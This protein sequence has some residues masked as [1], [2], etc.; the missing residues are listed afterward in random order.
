M[1]KKWKAAEE[2][3][4]VAQ[5]R[6]ETYKVTI[7]MQ[8]YIKVVLIWKDDATKQKISHLIREW[9]LVWVQILQKFTW[10]LKYLLLELCSVLDPASRRYTRL[11]KNTNIASTYVLHPFLGWHQLQVYGGPKK[12]SCFILLLTCATLGF[13]CILKLLLHTG[14]KVLDPKS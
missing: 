10:R 3:K 11:D 9:K 13:P 4:P 5:S 14:S 8:K 1:G 6:G 2:T 12:N 7:I